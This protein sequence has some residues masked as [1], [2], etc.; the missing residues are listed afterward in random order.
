M[1]R[2][3]DAPSRFWKSARHGQIAD[4]PTRLLSASLARDAALQAA[5]PFL[6]ALRA[7]FGLHAA[8]VVRRLTGA[9]ARVVLRDDHRPTG[10]IARWNGGTPA[11][12]L[13]TGSRRAREHG[14]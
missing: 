10:K 14:P 3:E 9:R 6:V 2:G 8:A 7:T 4:V 1:A 13:S 12:L 5:L 11:G